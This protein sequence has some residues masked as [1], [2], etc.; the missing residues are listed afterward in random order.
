MQAYP[1]VPVIILFYNKPPLS[2]TFL[3]KI[4]PRRPQSTP[5]AEK[6]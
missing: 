3:G 5:F 6:M 4:F 1:P 2:L